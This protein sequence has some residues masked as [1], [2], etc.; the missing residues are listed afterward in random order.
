MQ[1]GVRV[2]EMGD[3]CLR[4]ILSTTEGTFHRN[5]NNVSIIN[6]KASNTSQRLI[7]SRNIHLQKEVLHNGNII[8]KVMQISKGNYYL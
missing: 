1:A 7:S 4:I 8:L 5:K 3:C 6:N 2:R